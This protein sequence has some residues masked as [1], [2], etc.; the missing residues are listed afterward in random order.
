LTARRTSGRAGGF[1]LLEV[2]IALAILAGAMMAV[3]QMT[4]AALA[5]HGRAA[6]LEVATLL[7]RGKLAGLQ[8]TYEK[9][10]FRDFDQTDEGTFD[11]DGHPEVRWKLE[12]LKPQVE[13]GPDQILGLLMG[14]PGDSSGGMD[15][16]SLLG[17]KAQEGASDPQSG[18][19]TVFPGAA[20]MAGVLRLQ[21][22]K[23]G[24][25]IKK[26]VREIRLTVSWKD[27]ARDESF[28]VV[29]HLVAFARGTTP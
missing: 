10:G 16:A 18:I 26:G 9:D 2:M 19:E 25:Q 24:E 5:N 27:G 20:G 8:D 28:T 12:V 7:A 17:A 6:R 11:S 22:T 4:S 3:S 21:L 13:L 14:A 23:I 15:L 29:T 1:T